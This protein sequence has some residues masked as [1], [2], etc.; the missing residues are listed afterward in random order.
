MDTSK[1]KGG[2]DHEEEELKLTYDTEEYEDE[3]N[4]E[5][6][7]AEEESEEKKEQR[8]LP[9]DSGGTK[10]E[11]SPTEVGASNTEAGDNYR[12]EDYFE[13]PSANQYDNT[14]YYYDE[15]ESENRSRYEAVGK[16]RLLR[17]SYQSR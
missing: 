16:F 6:E 17:C 8:D 1:S 13:D 5:E 10:N 12:N 2:G 14:Y 7:K 4:Y 11:R 15:Y 3:D 9:S